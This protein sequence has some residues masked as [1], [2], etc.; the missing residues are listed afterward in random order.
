M[1]TVLIVEDDTLL[2]QA[3]AQALDDGGFKPLVARSKDEAM[4][5]LEAQPVH[6]VYLDIMLPGDDG[7]TILNTLKNDDKYR[8]IP[9]IM[10]SNL[11]QMGEIDKAMEMGAV[12]YVTKSSIDLEKIVE[13]TREKIG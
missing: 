6:L 12:D 1:K 13:L 10:L 9:V 4:Q 3:L 7:F 2:G 5:A 8:D 11:S